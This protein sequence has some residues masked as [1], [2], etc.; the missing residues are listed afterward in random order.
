MQ[1]FKVQGYK[2]ELTDNLDQ[3]DCYYSAIYRSAKHQNLL[4]HLF[5]CLRS[6]SN[7]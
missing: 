2:P 1:S 3:G 7:S 5:D 4:D 6:N